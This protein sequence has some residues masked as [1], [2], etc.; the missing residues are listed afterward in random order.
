MK[1]YYAP[2]ACSLAPLIVATEAGI[3]LDLVK[4]DIGSTPHTLPNGEP[5]ATVNPKLYVPVLEFDD[6]SRLTEVAVL[7]QYL[8]DLAPGTG[9]APEPDDQRRYRLQEWLNFISSELHKAFSPWLFHPELGT[10]AQDAVR[11]RLAGR[12]AYLDEQLAG[13]EYLLGGYSVADA[14]LFTILSWAKFAKV[15]LGDFPNVLAWQA[16]V[17]ARPAVR[18]ALRRHV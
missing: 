8:A 13:R 3:A 16:R 4:V 14:Y 2:N 18:E 5:Y 1:L 9:L 17:A 11:Q 15:P 12:L 7:L 6:G 10:V